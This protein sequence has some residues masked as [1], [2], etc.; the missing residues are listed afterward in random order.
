M[1]IFA[2]IPA[3]NEEKN[4]QKVIEDVK[5]NVA[6]VV[7][8]D[9]GSNDNTCRL[10]QNCGVVVLEHL[11]NLGQGA[12]LQTGNDY[13]L[14]NGAGIVVHFDADGQ[15][16]AEDIKDLVEPLLK[17]EVDITLGS[18]F[19]GKVSEIPWSKKWLIFKPA[20]FF[21]NFLS[22]LK[23]SD[24]HNGI[25][26]L[27]RKAL[28]KIQITQNQMGH[29]TEIC[30][31]IYHHQLRYREVPVKVIYNE[32]GQGFLAGLKILKDLFLDKLIR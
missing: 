11:I 17:D 15:H 8:I 2:I 22:G 25:R 32:Y 14:R 24:V 19:L 9:D 13:A 23:L 21:N 26:A 29:N 6:Q 5:R 31:L 30:S 20:V 28:K 16:L 18:R 10:A 27:N 1:K 12:A 7:V 4:I 3:Y